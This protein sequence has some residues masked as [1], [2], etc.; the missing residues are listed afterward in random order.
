MGTNPFMTIIPPEWNELAEINGPHIFSFEVA[1]VSGFLSYLVND[2][3]QP[4]VK[5]LTAF[6]Y[7]SAVRFFLLST[8]INVEFMDHNVFIQAVRRG[9]VNTSYKQTG[10]SSADIVRLPLSIDILIK[11]CS[12]LSDTPEDHM[13]RT[14]ALFGY[15][16]L[17]RVSEYLVT[18][19]S[20]HHI[21]SQ[22][23]SF[24][25]KVNGSNGS[26]VFH[27][28]AQVHLVANSEIVGVEITVRDSKNDPT[29]VGFKS[30]HS[31]VKVRSEKS[32]YDLTEV[33]LSW[34]IVSRPLKDEPFFSYKGKALSA[35]VLNKWLSNV[36]KTNNLDPSRVSSH[37]LRIGGAS[38]LAAA[39]VPDYLIQRLGRW[40]SLAFLQYV[41]L[42]SSAFCTASDSLSDSTNFTLNDMKLW[43][44]AIKN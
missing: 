13:L 7:L 28:P 12:L 29:G 5:P 38:A 17:C 22:A 6:N 14:A 41:R 40:N 25:Q 44:P 9:L 42:A 34:A 32:V 37:S 31:R 30:F 26:F 15:S 21:K 2:S 10:F 33:L 27:S 11:A 4:K 43:N 18:S 39:N 1:C 23:V 24:A 16:L 20:N 36:A 3:R 19:S 8:G 35:S